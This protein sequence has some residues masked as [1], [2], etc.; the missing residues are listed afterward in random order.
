M[1]VG[2]FGV[3]GLGT[4]AWLTGGTIFTVLRWNEVSGAGIDALGDGL[5]G[6]I[7]P[8]AFLWIIIATWLQ[9]QELSL[10][11]QE[12]AETRAV[13]GEQQKELENT[14]KENAEQTR[15]MQQTLHV[16]VEQ[17]VFE[18][19]KLR[20]Y[21]LAR[22]IATVARHSSML[23]ADKK[24]EI[25]TPSLYSAVGN[26]LPEDNIVKVD[27]ILVSFS[28]SLEDF[29]KQVALAGSDLSPNAQVR[30][31]KVLQIAKYIRDEAKSLAETEKYAKKPL[32]AA[33]LKGIEFEAFCYNAVVTVNV[34]SS[35]TAIWQS[36]V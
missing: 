26:I 3:G 5:S 33:R 19:H 13:L 35:A 25:I 6:W 17:A 22:Y 1:R 2:A 4:A 11:R 15:I 12:L 24:N 18:E 10:Q 31:L 29:Q 8:L 23:I 9:R 7:A 34:L 14:A 32:I 30:N 16:N 36:R 27:A 28:T 21:Y 20:M